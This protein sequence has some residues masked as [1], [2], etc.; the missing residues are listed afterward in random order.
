MDCMIEL[1]RER[2]I[3]LKDVKKINVK[4]YQVAIDISDNNEPSTEYASKFSLQY[5]TAL[6]LLRGEGG[7]DSFNSESL[8]DKEIRELMKRVELIADPEIDQEDTS[9]KEATNEVE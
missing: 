7:L 3:I 9:K 8:W 4:T 2:K 5:C 6:A 1:A